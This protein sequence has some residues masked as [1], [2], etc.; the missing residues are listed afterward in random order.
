MS[1]YSKQTRVVDLSHWNTVTDFAAM[2]KAG[3]VGVIHKFSQG[4]AYKDPQFWPRRKPALAAGLLWGR[5]HFGDGSPVPQ[6]V[7]NFLTDW[8]DPKEL[9]A[10]DWEEVVGGTT[11]TLMQAIEFVELV[12][13]RTGQVPVLYS[14]NI[15]KEALKGT[16]NPA[17]N[18]CRLWLAHYSNAPVCPP[19]WDYP[20][21]WQHSDKGV[22][23]GVSGDADINAFPGEADPDIELDNLALEWGGHPR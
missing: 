6:Q 5:Y 2:H 22:V 14:G 4:G 3:V 23:P 18:R 9:L 21:I 20:W 13:M 7:N 17:L 10:L 12:E 19:G 8:E 1:E 15:A 16:P 11:M